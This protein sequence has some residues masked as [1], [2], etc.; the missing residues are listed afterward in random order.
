VRVDGERAIVAGAPAV[1]GI[2]FNPA[3]G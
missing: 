2:M 3:V 1:D